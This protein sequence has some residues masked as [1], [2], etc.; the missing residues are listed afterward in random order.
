M[1]GDYLLDTNIVIAIL[2]GDK[3]VMSE[4]ARAAAIYHPAIVIGEL[5]YGAF[6]SS[7]KNE[8][9]QRIDIYKSDVVILNCDDDTAKY[10]GEIKTELKLKGRPIPENDVWI[11]ALAK[12]YSL[13]LVTRDKH[14]NFIERLALKA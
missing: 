11:A 8:N 1:S 13:T 10:Y 2:E 7:K 9:T 5:Y 4:V 12:Q 14:F 6:N 3:R